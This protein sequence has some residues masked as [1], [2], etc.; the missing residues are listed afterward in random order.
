MSIEK[1]IQFKLSPFLIMAF[2]SSDLRLSPFQSLQTR[3]TYNRIIHIIPCWNKVACDP[4][5]WQHNN[6]NH[7]CCFYSVYSSFIPMLLE[8]KLYDSIVQIFLQNFIY[9]IEVNWI[10]KFNSQKNGCFFYCANNTN[11]L[12]IPMFQNNQDWTVKSCCCVQGKFSS[13][14]TPYNWQMLSITRNAQMHTT[15]MNI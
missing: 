3:Q 2:L 1:Q 13:L 5:I 8:W 7:V 9:Q 4:F 10:H 11:N 15:K 14:V 6:R 12:I